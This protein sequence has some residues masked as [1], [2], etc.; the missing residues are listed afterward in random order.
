VLCPPILHKLKRI[1]EDRVESMTEELAHIFAANISAG[2]GRRCGAEFHGC[3]WW[4]QSLAC[5]ACDTG[6]KGCG[7]AP[8]VRPTTRFPFIEL[9]NSICLCEHC[10]E[11]ANQLVCIDLHGRRDKETPILAQAIPFNLLNVHLI[12][13]HFIEM[14]D[15]VSKK[16]L[17][18]ER[19]CSFA[20]LLIV[21]FVM[22]LSRFAN[23]MAEI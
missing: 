10:Q 17:M 7:A 21:D 3:F 4:R 14:W 2:R 9:T 1:V 23:S 5:G 11:S 8:A 20:R 6:G 16:S 13:A 18:P 19:E 12:T 15:S 22:Q